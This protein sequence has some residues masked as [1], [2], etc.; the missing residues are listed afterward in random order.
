MKI[1]HT[2]VLIVV[3]FACIWASNNV[4]FVKNIVGQ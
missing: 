1:W 4:Q 2:V 3:V